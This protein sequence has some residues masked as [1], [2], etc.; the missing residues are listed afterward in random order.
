MHQVSVKHPRVAC[1]TV[2]SPSFC[3][4]CQNGLH[5]VSVKHAEKYAKHSLHQISIKHARMAAVCTNNNRCT[6]FFPRWVKA[7]QAIDESQF[8]HQAPRRSMSSSATPATQHEVRC[9]Q[10]PR[11]PGKVPRRHGRLMAPKRATRSTPMSLSATPATQ[12]EGRCR[13]EPHLPRKTKGRGRQ[14]P[15]PPRT[16]PRHDGRLMA[17]KRAT[18][19]NP[20]P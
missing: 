1:T 10:V 14:V 11:L 7:S 5:K 15:R 18:R 12:S 8:C 3:E 6:C 20:V 13:Q 4:T 19:S 9:C 2:L 16:V 17:P